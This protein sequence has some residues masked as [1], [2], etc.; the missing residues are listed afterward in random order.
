MFTRMVKSL[1]SLKLTV[2]L[3]ALAM[4][5]ILAGTFAQIDHPIDV[6]QKLY[7]HS[8][9]VWIPV[10]IFFPRTPG[11][12]PSLGLHLPMLGGYAI[13]LLLI[14][15]LI[16]A[17]GL[18][19]KQTWR[20]LLLLPLLALMVVPL[21]VWQYNDADWLFRFVAHVGIDLAKFSFPFFVWVVLASA[22][23][24]LPFYLGLFM[25]HGKRGGIIMIHLGVL[26][27]LIG[28]GITSQMQV[29]SQMPIDVGSYAHY[30]Q[31]IYNAEL[32]IVDPSPADHN[33]QIV[34]PASLL[35]SRGSIRDS[36]LPF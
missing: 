32:A 3:L 33:D 29:E 20:D 30:T 36:K 4:F 10:G 35:A 16:A 1:S 8:L 22:L 14:V 24:G 9:L 31:D 21:V 6:V 15:N 26:G 18:R 5:L 7:F 23:L 12:Q 19:F 25:L 11:G 34:I 2:V 13:G 28:E 17:H 27:L